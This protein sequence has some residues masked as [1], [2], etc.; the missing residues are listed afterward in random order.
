MCGGVNSDACNEMM[1][2]PKCTSKCDGHRYNTVRY[3]KIY[4]IC[5]STLLALTVNKTA[6]YFSWQQDSYN[7]S[8]TGCLIMKLNISTSA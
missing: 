5:V 4:G 8:Y 6:F 7:S 2:I 1:I 3:S